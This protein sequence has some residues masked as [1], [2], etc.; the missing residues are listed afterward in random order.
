VLIPANAVPASAVLT[1][2]I[3]YL[4]WE[5]NHLDHRK[6]YSAG[7]GGLLTGLAFGFGP[8][9]LTGHP[10]PGSASV[11]GCSAAVASAGSSRSLSASVPG[12]TEDQ[13]SS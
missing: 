12:S 5:V 11:L 4:L 10:S 13:N 7:L 6:G 2:D 8:G 1:A 3:A 9:L